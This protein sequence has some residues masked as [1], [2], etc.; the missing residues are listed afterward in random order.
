MKKDGLDD[1]SISIRIALEVAF[2]TI[3]GYM[4]NQLV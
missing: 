1:K 2:G 3:I 4:L